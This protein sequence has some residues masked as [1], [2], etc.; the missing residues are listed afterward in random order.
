MMKD[1]LFEDRA[2]ELIDW[3]HQ[4]GRV[5]LDSRKLWL[6]VYHQ[7][8]L[9]GLS[10]ETRVHLELIAQINQRTMPKR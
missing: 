4:I 9:A 3:W 10:S 6:A 8:D 2:A 1:V 5:D 7:H